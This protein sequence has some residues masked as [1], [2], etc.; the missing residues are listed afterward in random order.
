M[1]ILKKDTS[2]SNVKKEL[3]DPNFMKLLKEYDKDNISQNLIKRIQKYTSKMTTSKIATISVAAAVMWDW[4]LA[5]ESY[6]MAFQEIEPK[7]KKVNMLKEK[8]KKSEDELQLM[9]ENDAKFTQQIEQNNI[10]LSKIKAEVD[11]YQVEA[12]IQQNKLDN[13]EKLLSGLSNT[14]EGWKVRKSELQQRFEWLVGDC[15]ISS[16]FLSYMGPFPSEY[17][18]QIQ[19]KVLF[20]NVNLYNISHNVNYKFS[21]FLAKPTDLLTWQLQGL[22]SDQFSSDNGVLVNKSRRFSLM[23]DPQMQANSW[24]KRM[25][26][27]N[28]KNHKSKILILDLQTDNFMQKIEQSV[29]LGNAV[30]L[31]NVDEELDASLEPLLNKTIKKKAGKLFIYLGEDNEV[32]YNENFRMYITT[33]MPNPRYK[34]EISTKVTLVNFTVKQKGLEE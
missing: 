25:E 19:E 26:L 31:Q 7:R 33:K 9:Y 11:G 23:I 24:I 14:N 34:A 18:E 2:W 5:M 12:Q 30:I 13:A 29:A 17:R 27:D 4:V 16:A 22:P 21:E 32:L 28:N 6:G 3:S 20:H 10:Q 15:L 1:T 8:L